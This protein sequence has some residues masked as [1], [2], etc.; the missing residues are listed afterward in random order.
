MFDNGRLLYNIFSS[1]VDVMVNG[2]LDNIFSGFSL[3]LLPC[4]L[5]CRRNRFDNLTDISFRLAMSIDG[6]NDGATPLMAESATPMPSV[7]DRAM[8]ATPSRRDLM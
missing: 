6:S 1:K 5:D 7:E 4:F 3:C 2:S 8:D